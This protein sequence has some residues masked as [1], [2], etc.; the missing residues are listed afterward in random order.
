MADPT[1]VFF[2]GLD[3]QEHVPLLEPV[4]GT[5]RF[6]LMTD[7]RVDHWMLRVNRGDV[8]V[9]RDEGPADAV[10]VTRR[11]LFNGVTTGSVNAVAALL[12][13][14][15]VAEG[16]LRLI[17]VLDRLLP[18]PPGARGARRPSRPGGGMAGV[19]PRGPGGLPAPQGAPEQ[20]SQR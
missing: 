9:S 8:A 4:E 11:D 6:D 10:V 1:E 15:I 14:A 19:P 5:V 13:G 18:G 2:E 3:R 17:L 12:R 20:T 7:G 16:D